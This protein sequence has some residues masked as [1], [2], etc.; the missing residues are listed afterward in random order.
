[1][2]V[3]IP[4]M[5]KEFGNNLDFI[6]KYYNYLTFQKKSNIKLNEKY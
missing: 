2:L 1:M 3:E 5:E 4:K 6:G